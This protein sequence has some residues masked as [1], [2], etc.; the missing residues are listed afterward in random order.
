MDMFS[1]GFDTARVVLQLGR[2]S[3]GFEITRNHTIISNRDLLNT[4]C[5]SC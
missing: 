4:G 3:L 2:K 5:G 1:T